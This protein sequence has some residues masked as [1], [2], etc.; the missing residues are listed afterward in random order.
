MHAARMGDSHGLFRDIDRGLTKDWRRHPCCPRHTWLRI[1]EADLK[2]L[3]DYFLYQNP[4]VSSG[5]SITP[6][7]L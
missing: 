1:P 4:S 5:L 3:S 2:P 7:T 6:G